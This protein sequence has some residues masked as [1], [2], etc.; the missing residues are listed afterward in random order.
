VCQLAIWKVYDPE[1]ISDGTGGALDVIPHN[2][3]ECLSAIGQAVDGA[4]PGCGVKIAATLGGLGD[5]GSE[6]VNVG[7]GHRCRSN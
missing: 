3:T 7:S 2:Q 1:G 5:Q 4:D 6:G